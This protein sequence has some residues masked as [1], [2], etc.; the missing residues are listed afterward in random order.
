ALA[1]FV[2]L[3]PY[4]TLFRSSRLDL[5]VL[6]FVTLVPVVVVIAW[7]LR[8]GGPVL[9]ATLSARPVVN[10]ISRMATKS[11]P[12]GVFGVSREMEYGLDRKSTR[13]NS[14]HVAISY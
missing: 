14:S 7:V 8:K 6:R 5:R 13:L 9:D 4:T 11:L 3:F 12:V 2:S 10:E 1:S